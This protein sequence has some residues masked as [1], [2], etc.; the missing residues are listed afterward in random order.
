MKA[1][2]L[3]FIFVVTYV[4]FAEGVCPPE[5]KASFDADF[6]KC[7]PQPKEQQ[8]PCMVALIRTQPEFKKYTDQ[9]K[10]PSVKGCLKAALVADCPDFANL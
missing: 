2:L 9:C 5:V 10:D 8:I 6:E 7:K 3:I 1:A 4:V